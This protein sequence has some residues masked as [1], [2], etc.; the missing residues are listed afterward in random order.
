MCPLYPDLR[1][2]RVICAFVLGKLRTAIPW[3]GSGR[4]PDYPSL[5]QAGSALARLP[6]G[7]QS[8]P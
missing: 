2:L 8:Q 3:P 4:I 1:N 5:A 7:W 6:R